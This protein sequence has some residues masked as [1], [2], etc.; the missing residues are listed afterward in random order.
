MLEGMGFE[1]GVQTGLGNGTG[2]IG[3]QPWP[4]PHQVGT[5]AH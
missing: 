5:V 4:S 1:G 2:Q 3:G